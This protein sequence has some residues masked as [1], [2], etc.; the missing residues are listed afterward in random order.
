MSKVPKDLGKKVQEE[1]QHAIDEW[2][3]HIPAEGYY[4][5]PKT[6]KIEREE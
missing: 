2:T 5:N 1:L 6:Q 3:K 4:K